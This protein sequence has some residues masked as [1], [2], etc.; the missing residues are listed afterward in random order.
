[1]ID[2]R[3]VCSCIETHLGGCNALEHQEY[4]IQCWQ[5]LKCYQSIAYITQ[6]L[7]DSSKGTC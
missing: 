2:V 1:M 6:A 4:M 5:R 3:T 7:C